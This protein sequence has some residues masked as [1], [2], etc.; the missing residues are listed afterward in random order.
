MG[1]TIAGLGSYLPE[2]TLTNDDL[3]KLVETNDEWIVSRTGIRSRHQASPGQ[4]TSDLAL[5][6]SRQALAAAG[7]KPEDLDLIVLATST[8][9]TPVPPTACWL[10]HALGAF[11]APAF[12]VSAACTGFLYAMHVGAGLIRGG[13]HRNVLVVGAET[14]TRMTDYSDRAS[15]ILCGAGAGPAVL[16]PG[17]DIELMYSS[18]AADGRAAEM[19]Q[20]EAGGSRLPASIATVESHQHYIKL[21]GNEVFKR[22]VQTMAQAARTALA[23]MNLTV[24]D[25]AWFLPHQANQRIT[26][27]VASALE[28][29]M[30]RVVSEM[31]QVGNTAAASLPVALSHL[32]E[33]RQIKPGDRLMLV[34]FGAGATWGCQVYQYLPRASLRA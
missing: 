15:G 18:I 23:E 31:S 24:E 13:M 8:A 28:L 17:G 16:A 10:Q 9:D 22:A 21:K 29:P 6:A 20:I 7:L 30:E 1:V 33:S 26:V 14:L 5:P 25:I 12:D 32:V 2:G 27:A 4:A 3:S 19:I 34:G 11:N